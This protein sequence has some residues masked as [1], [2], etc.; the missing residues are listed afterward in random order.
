MKLDLTDF[1]K[2][3]CD[4]TEKLM[5]KTGSSYVVLDDANNVVLCDGDTWIKWHL[6][7]GNTERRIIKRTGNVSTVFLATTL[8]DETGPFE[9][10]DFGLDE[11]NETRYATYQEALDGHEAACKLAAERMATNER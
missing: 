7:P 1:Q 8:D 2:A 9:T 5:A 3:L 4:L 11:S 6:K 10:I